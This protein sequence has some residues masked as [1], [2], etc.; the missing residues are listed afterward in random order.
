VTDEYAG[1]HWLSSFVWYLSTRAEG[2]VA[3]GAA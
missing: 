3:P 1:A 2:G